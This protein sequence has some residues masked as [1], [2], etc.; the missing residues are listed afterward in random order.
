MSKASF[1]Q[2]FFYFDL[3]NSCWIF[4]F[5]EELRLDWC[6]SAS[7]LIDSLNVDKWFNPMLL[8]CF[9]RLRR[10][11]PQYES[12]APEDFFFTTHFKAIPTLI[13]W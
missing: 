13:I 8:A 9:T 3:R 7:L 12:L 4:N 11:L 2:L 5:V 6:H 1:D 10:I